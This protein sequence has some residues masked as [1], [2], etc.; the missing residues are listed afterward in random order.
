[1]N[2]IECWKYVVS[3]LDFGNRRRTSSGETNCKA[4][5][6]LLTQ[7]CVEYTLVAFTE[8]TYK[9]R[10]LSLQVCVTDRHAGSNLL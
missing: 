8:Q 9:P 7:R 2:L 4:D 6:A 1:M 10:C 3:K 5:D